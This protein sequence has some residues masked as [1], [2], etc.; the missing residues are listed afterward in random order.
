[1]PEMQL[2][3]KYKPYPEF[4]ANI[5]TNLKTEIRSDEKEL[6]KKSGLGESKTALYTEK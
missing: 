5:E 1:V 4:C 3:H 6:K 2:C